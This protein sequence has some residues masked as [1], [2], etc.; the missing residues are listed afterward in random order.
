[1][2]YPETMTETPK[3]PN[4]QMPATRELSPHEVRE[5]IAGAHQFFDEADLPLNLK[6]EVFV[7]NWEDAI[8]SGRGVILAIFDGDKPAAGLGAI[9]SPEMNSDDLVAMECWWH[10]QKPYRSLGYGQRLLDA[11][12][13]WAEKSGA[14]NAFMIHLIE[15]QPEKLGALYEARGYRRVEV[16]YVKGIHK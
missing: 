14:V 6:P 4:A 15:L 7:K 5:C 9:L 3:C 1:M 12:E 16:V 8:K 11:Y 13:Q 2:Q 10:V